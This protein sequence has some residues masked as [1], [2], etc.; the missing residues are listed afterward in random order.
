MVYEIMLDLAWI[1]K[2]VVL[3]RSDTLSVG[4][5]LKGKRSLF[6]NG[7]GSE[8]VR[9]MVDM[10]YIIVFWVIFLRLDNVIRPK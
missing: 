7:W 8:I 6:V 2:F 9:C 4:F 5:G 10:Y 3:R 1:F